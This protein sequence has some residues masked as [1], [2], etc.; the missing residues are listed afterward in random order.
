MLAQSKIQA[1]RFYPFNEF[2]AELPLNGNDDFRAH[3]DE[4]VAARG[5]DALPLLVR[6][7]YSYDTAWVKR[8]T[9]YY[10]KL[11]QDQISGFIFNVAKA[12]QDIDAS[13]RIRSDIPYS[14]FL[15]LGIYAGEQGN[16]ADLET[17]FLQRIAKFP[18]YYPLYRYRLKYLYPQWGGSVEA[19]K[20]FVDEYAGNTA[21]GSP[22]RMLY[23]ALYKGLMNAAA[24]QCE[25]SDNLSLQQQCITR[26][27]ND[28]VTPKIESNVVS[29]LGL[30]QT[31]DKAQFSLEL[32]FY[33][34][35]MARC[36]CNDPAFG[37]FLQT[38]ADAMGTDT[39]LDRD[40]TGQDNYVLDT[41]AGDIQ[42]HRGAPDSAA[43]KYQQAVD[44][45]GA[46]RF[47]D[48]GS[49]DL[50]LA[51]VYDRMATLDDNTSQHVAD[52]AYTEAAIA[53][54]G[55]SSSNEPYRA[56]AAYWR[57]K[58]YQAGAAACSKLMADGVGA[59]A[60]GSGAPI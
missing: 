5:G 13:I 45:I 3:L 31:M 40:T 36:D 43:T 44:D 19:M 51:Y 30:Y 26:A 28:A 42:A 34:G 50:A 29:A 39:E 11:N 27:V 6:A 53:L 17:A 47:P 23:I 46:M 52:I 59:G 60:S 14:Y 2:I 15:R 58:L 1:W 32:Q 24:Y 20:A 10:G 8:G 57:L 35:D 7:E 41:A 49:R 38:A 21:A 9:D 4:W 56:C 33:M 37:I 55:I 25:D 18:S 48:Q 22:Q 12:K 16:S 54:G